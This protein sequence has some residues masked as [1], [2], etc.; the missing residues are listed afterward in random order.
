MTLFDEL[1]GNQDRSKVITIDTSNML[2]DVKDP[3]DPTKLVC[4]LAFRNVNTNPDPLGL[5]DTSGYA[6][7]DKNQWYV[8]SAFFDDYTIVYDAE[9]LYNQSATD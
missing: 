9:G 1:Y 5:S 2:I 7:F 8:G 3:N 4:Q 6:N